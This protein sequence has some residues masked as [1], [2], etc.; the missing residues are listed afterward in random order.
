[1]SS[2]DRGEVSLATGGAERDAIF[3]RINGRAYKAPSVWATTLY[4]SSSVY[5]HFEGAGGE[6]D[7]YRQEVHA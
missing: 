4:A 2:V 1:M 7:G 5:R 3:I 6:F